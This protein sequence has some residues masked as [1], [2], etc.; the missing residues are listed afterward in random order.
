MAVYLVNAKYNLALQLN[1]DET[2][3][4]ATLVPGAKDQQWII[5]GQPN[6]TV[7]LKNVLYQLYINVNGV[8]AAGLPIV[9]LASPSDWTHVQA[10]GN[11]SEQY[12]IQNPAGSNFSFELSAAT[13]G[14][15]I[16]LQTQAQG[17]D[18]FWFSQN[19]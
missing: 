2:I 14:T 8:P 1:E 7:T 12:F 9:G 10:V 17:S 5:T 3:T 6:G 18:Q 4:G 13:A 16:V 15:A 19:V 11:D